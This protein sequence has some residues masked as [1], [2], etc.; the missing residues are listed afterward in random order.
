MI[1]RIQTIYQ[2]IVLVMMALLLKA[3]LATFELASSIQSELPTQISFSAFGIVDSTEASVRATI[4]LGI[5]VSIVAAL[6]FVNIFL[7]KRRM[8]QVRLCV[9]QMILLLGTMG[10]MAYYHYSLNNLVMSMGDYVSKI[11]IANVAPVVALV[12]ARLAMRAI[13]SDEYLVRSAD[14]IR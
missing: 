1:Q 4:Y 6:A 10:F 3:N 9:M 2:L 11:S 12:F 14:R 13:L 7:F 8:L 5:L